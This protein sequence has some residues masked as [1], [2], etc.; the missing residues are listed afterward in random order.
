[1]LLRKL[2][3]S[4]GVFLHR[5]SLAM[6]FDSRVCKSNDG[7]IQ[8]TTQDSQKV[9]TILHSSKKYSDPLSHTRYLYLILREAKK[10][11]EEQP[12]LVDITV[13]QY[14]S[15]TVCG[16]THGQYYDL[17]NI[18]EINGLPGDNNMYLFNGDFVDRGMEFIC[19]NPSIGAHLKSMQAAFLLKLL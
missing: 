12:T 3:C 2:Y 11:F 17:L 14:H 10:L 5:Y 8:S 18:F 7:R 16:D 13:D 6:A 15:L 19:L 1:M 4:G 9:S